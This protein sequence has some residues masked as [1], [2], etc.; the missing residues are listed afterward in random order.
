M[1][2]NNRT[3][4]LYSRLGGYVPQP[5]A[6]SSSACPS[7]S[8]SPNSALATTS[9]L[10]S[11]VPSY[12]PH[13]RDHCLSGL[14]LQAAQRQHALRFRNFSPL[15]PQESSTISFSDSTS[16]SPFSCRS[17]SQN[18]EP[19]T[20]VQ[21]QSQQAIAP[22]YGQRDLSSASSHGSPSSTYQPVP[23]CNNVSDGALGRTDR[24]DLSVPT[25]P[26]TTIRSS[27]STHQASEELRGASDAKRL[28]RSL[29]DLEKELLTDD[30][31]GLIGSFSDMAAGS[32]FRDMETSSAFPLNAYD[33]SGLTDI[34]TDERDWTD[35]IEDFFPVESSS[36][37]TTIDQST[38]TSVTSGTSAATP[39]SKV[40]TGN[41]KE[42]LLACADAINN[43]AL[44]AAKTS[45][46][47]LEQSVSIYGDPLQRLAAYMADALSA[48][49]ER[50]EKFLKAM[51][52]ASP[53]EI[54]QSTQV[55][56]QSCLHVKFGYLAANAAIAE[57]CRNE[58]HIHIVDFNIGQGNQWQTL[59]GA[60]SQRPGGPPHI[61]I[62]GISDTSSPAN[63]VGVVQKLQEVARRAG[64]PLEF[65]YL[66]M[67]ASRVEP[68]MLLTKPGEALAVNLAFQLHKMADES[69][70]TSNPRDGL[71]RKVKSLEPK[72]VTI[73]EHDANM[74]T[75]PF[76]PRFVEALDYFNALFESLDG[77]LT[78]DN[79][80]RVNAEKFGLAR[81]IMNIVA[82]EGADR[83]QRYEVAG[84]WHARM[85][86]AGFRSLPTNPSTSKLIKDLLLPYSR[87]YKIKE[88][89]GA[90][91]LNWVD[92]SLV[93]ASAW[94]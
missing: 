78:R 42:L 20:C 44:T 75:A 13:S 79:K 41:P 51:K 52:D 30:S 39:H 28:K 36:P 6:S 65:R 47:A 91:H 88:E 23:Q 80:D 38:I 87:K 24:F 14:K 72:V 43:D 29:E 11:P 68:G 9:S 62:T 7:P 81:D 90:L 59:I 16:S 58:R 34:V 83:I 63:T 94:H 67:E 60:F 40:S 37:T 17:A 71:L 19:F 35:A 93:F 84:K 12:Q 46:L 31:F 69:V 85:M 92:R 18:R 82:C 2:N 33:A 73:V 4:Q 54:L 74:N 70:S 26:Q 45:L 3:P 86:M 48:R 89:A 25:V 66:Q 55:L 53:I 61:R 56:Y 27:K 57:A 22:S 1:N 21:S 8:P 49:L 64:V 15:S 76:Y 32:F 50:N 77:A 5:P 10:V